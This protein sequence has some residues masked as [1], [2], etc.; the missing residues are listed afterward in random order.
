RSR[1]PA[2]A[3]VGPRGPPGWGQDPSRSTAQ[4]CE[5][6]SINHRSNPDPAGVTGWGSL[7]CSV[8]RGRFIRPHF[9]GH[10]GGRPTLATRDKPIVSFAK[11]T[12][13]MEMPNLL[14]VQLRAFQTLL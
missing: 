1:P 6:R 7:C 14:D 2:V 10:S 8:V 4:W 3:R 12:S 9:F 11:L 5:R 13:G